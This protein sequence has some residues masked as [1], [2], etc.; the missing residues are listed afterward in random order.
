MAGD[1]LKTLIKGVL[2]PFVG[3]L[4]W[5]VLVAFNV[6]PQSLAN[7][8]E[9]PIVIAF[10]IILFL[11]RKKLNYKISLFLLISFVSCL[12]YFMPLIPE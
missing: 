4:V 3:V 10:S 1:G 2:L 8:I 7:L 11:F 6:G 5:I 12:R 9:I